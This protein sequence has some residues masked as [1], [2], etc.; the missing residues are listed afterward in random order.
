LTFEEKVKAW[1]VFVSMT[2]AITALVGGVLLIG[3]YIDEQAAQEANRQEQAKQELRFKHAEALRLQ[4]AA[5]QQRH[6]RKRKS[7]DEAKKVAQELAGLDEKAVD[8]VK[9]GPKRQQFEQMYW[10][11]LIGVEDRHVESAMIRLRKHLE[12]WVATGKKP[13]GGDYETDVNQAALKL[14]QACERDVQ[15]LEDTINT[16]NE[17]IVTL[18]STPKP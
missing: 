13:L 9:G 4:V 12:Q 10:A 1:E 18:N 8:Q 14:S 3:K 5:L 6:D 7:Y 2:S 16:L 17:Q 11:D 15:A